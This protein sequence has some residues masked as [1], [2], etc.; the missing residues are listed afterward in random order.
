MNGQVRTNSELLKE[1]A[2][3]KQKIQELEQ[4]ESERKRA[5]EELRKSEEKYRTL[6][7]NIQDGIYILDSFGNFTFVNDVIVKRS[8][9]PAEWF[10][11]R[12]YIDVIIEEDRER[13]QKYF[14]AVID[15]KTQLYDL[16][17]P[18]K[19]GNLLQVEVSTAPLFDGAKVIALLGISRDISERRRLEEA[20]VKSEE[21]LR[22]ITE[23][24][25][26]CVALVDASGTYQ[27]VTP[28]YREVLGHCP[29]DMIGISG[30]SLLHPDD[31]ER[32]LKLY[33][34]G[35]EQ[36]LREIRYEMRFRHRNGHYVPMEI[37]ARSLK[38]TQGKFMGGVVA[39]RDITERLQIDEERKQAEEE[40]RKSEEK[41]RAIIESMEDG[42]HEVDLKGN[43][44]L[45]NE[46]TRKIMGYER[47]A[48]LGMN[49]HQYADEK[50]IRKIYQVYNQVY[51]TGEPV[52]NF[53]WQI[54]RKDGDRRD[55]EVSIS[56][57]RNTEGHPTGFRGIVR[58]TTDRKRAEKALR[59]SENKFRSFADHSLVGIYLNQ[60]GVLKYVNPK[61]AEI[62]GYTVEE[63]SENMF[64]RDLVYPEDYATVK[65]QVRK[66]LSGEIQHVHYTFRGIKKTGEIIHVEI[67]GSSIMFN[68]R[69]TVTGTILDITDRK[70]AETEKVK[71]EEQYRQ[72]Q[73][74]E[75]IGQ[76]AGG[77][78]HDF[79]NMLNIILGYSQLALIKIEPSDPLHTNIQEIMN[80][81]RRSSDL[82]R[83]LLAFARK[84]TIAPKTLDLNDI[85]AGTLNM[86]RKL[87]GEDIDLL[88]M[89]AASLWPVKMDPAQV[90]QLLANLAVNARDSISGVGKI[91]IET[92]NEEFDD[93]YCAQRAGFVPGLYSMLAVSDNGCGMDKD[94]C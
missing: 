33:M 7:E 63:C 39:A 55:I 64:F 94:T 46:S 16:S 49:Y 48:L 89:P 80:A 45:F 90:D 79:N 20:L 52:K 42:Y 4:S 59:E 8:G 61:F 60:D 44:T 28:S 22:Q 66:R 6:I 70:R 37:R 1:N 17:Y 35:I 26:D 58:D 74:M 86:L 87:I 25:V 27:Y 40:L 69:A 83:Q 3:L 81:A 34:D 41:Y 77:V 92:G 72:A 68:G 24:M 38:D 12:S 71:L 10:L 14:N 54:I 50:N 51:R 11:G 18:R 57:I 21:K 31:L 36:G 32:V 88:W 30:F 29:E 85:V 65:E 93:S 67:F 84:Q 73:K 13:V 15:G 9:F 56:L 75:A 19:S 62:F 82:V 53:E 23:N 43:Y 2:F 91:T 5:E 78:A 76:L 47:E